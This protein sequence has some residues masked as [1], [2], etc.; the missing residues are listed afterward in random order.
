MKI[1]DARAEYYQASGR[2]SELCRKA[3]FAG[4][5]IVWIFQE[6]GKGAHLDGDL[7]YPLV[8]LTLALVLDLMQYLSSAIV[9]GVYA[10]W[11]EHL[12]NI[13][14]Y[15]DTDR[16]VPSWFNVPTNCLFWSKVGA[17][18]LGYVLIYC[19]VYKRLL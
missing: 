10:R 4:I 5:A 16:K 12:V 6:S 3:C 8:Y 13:G 9:W 19:L 2:V 15:Q 14:R 18:I 1:A 7:L 11:R 17:A